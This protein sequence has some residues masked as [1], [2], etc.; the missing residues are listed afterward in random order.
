MGF[1]PQLVT[2]CHSQSQLSADTKAFQRGIWRG[3]AVDLALPW[4]PAVKNGTAGHAGIAR[5]LPRQCEVGC[6][7]CAHAA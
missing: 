1:E 4:Q 7:V 2:K 6:R 3:C 5:R